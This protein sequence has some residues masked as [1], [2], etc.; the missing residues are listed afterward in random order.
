MEVKG[1]E[2]FIA[3]SDEFLAHLAKIIRSA[4][5]RNCNDVD[6]L[7]ELSEIIKI[8]SASMKSQEDKPNKKLSPMDKVKKRA[9]TGEQVSV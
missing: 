3:A 9:S 6:E 2:E 7:R 8:N 1:T 4:I 5:A